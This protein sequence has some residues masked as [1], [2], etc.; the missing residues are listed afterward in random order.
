M[1]IAMYA[2]EGGNAPF[3]PVHVGLGCV[4]AVVMGVVVDRVIVKFDSVDPTP[5]PSSLA[6]T[7]SSLLFH[8]PPDIPP[9]MDLSALGNTL[10]PGLADAE[11]EMGDKFRGES[12]PAT[13][14]GNND[15]AGVVDAR[16]WLMITSG[17]TEHHQSVQKLAGV[18]K[19]EFGSCEEGLPSWQGQAGRSFLTE[20]SRA[21]LDSKHITPATPLVCESLGP[22]CVARLIRLRQDVLSTVQSAI[23]GGQDAEQTL[24][25][26]MDWAEAREV[27]PCSRF[28]AHC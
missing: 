10:P 21:D 15:P 18:H 5:H 13:L 7:I 3:V 14:I 6:A 17:G 20:S 8:T 1:P 27:G 23:A 26:L 12:S 16:T 11:R 22:L 4:L 28:R 25:R 2:S 24:S 19:G 9:N